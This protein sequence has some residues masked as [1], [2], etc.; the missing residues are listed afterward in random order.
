MNKKK[1]E[2]RFDR[3]KLKTKKKMEALDYF[4]VLN[5]EIKEKPICLCLDK[6]LLE[7]FNDDGETLYDEDKIRKDITQIFLY[8]NSES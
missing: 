1:P 7:D 3:K 6:E 5:D 8:C 4:S 2:Q